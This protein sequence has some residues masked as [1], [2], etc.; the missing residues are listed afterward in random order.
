MMTESEV[1]GGASRLTF[2]TGCTVSSGARYRLTQI[3]EAC[4]ASTCTNANEIKPV[5]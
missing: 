2:C 3:S 4:R 5:A 1:P